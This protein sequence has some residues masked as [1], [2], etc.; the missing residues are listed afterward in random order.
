[1]AQ[2]IYPEKGSDPIVVV[3]DDVFDTLTRMIN[4]DKF[5]G[6]TDDAWEIARVAIQ[7]DRAALRRKERHERGD[8]EPEL[9]VLKDLAE[10]VW[11]RTDGEAADAPNDLVNVCTA[12]MQHGFSKEGGVPELKR[13]YNEMSEHE[14]KTTELIVKIGAAIAELER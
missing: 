1:M 12:A 8:F 13:L 11:M 2:N 6:Q 3:E 14:N 7:L 5:A 9:Q 10:D 4:Y